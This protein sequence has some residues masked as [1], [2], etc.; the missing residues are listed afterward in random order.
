M[1]PT[2]Q[3]LREE[4][5]ALFGTLSSRQADCL[6]AL[7]KFSAVCSQVITS[8]VVKKHCVRLLSGESWTP[9][10]DYIVIDGLKIVVDSNLH[11][12]L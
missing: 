1:I 7:V 6:S 2:E 11:I 5:K 10:Y 12:S 3:C 9:L 4:D 8:E